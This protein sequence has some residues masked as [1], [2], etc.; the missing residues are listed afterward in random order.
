MRV[1]ENKITRHPCPRMLAQSSRGRRTRLLSLSRSRGTVSRNSPDRFHQ[2]HLWIA[3]VQTGGKFGREALDPVPRHE[4]FGFHSPFT[5]KSYAILSEGTCFLIGDTL[6]PI[7]LL[8]SEDHL[9]RQCRMSSALSSLP[10][11]RAPFLPILLR[12]G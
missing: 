6:L 4:Q 8:L 2:I 1:Q 3:S 10:S 9:F 7:K 12:I 5:R 11:S